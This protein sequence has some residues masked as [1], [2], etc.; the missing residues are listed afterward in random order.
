M[1]NAVQMS[2]IVRKRGQARP[3]YE[4]GRLELENGAYRR[5]H[6]STTPSAYSVASVTPTAAP[7]A[8]R[9]RLVLATKAMATKLQCP[10][11]RAKARH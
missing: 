11:F 7:L 9:S 1:L 2:K 10:D 4:K 3:G 5:T 6:P 8:P